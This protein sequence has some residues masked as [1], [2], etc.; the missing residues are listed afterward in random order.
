MPERTHGDCRR[1]RRAGVDGVSRVIGEWW[2]SD[3]DD[4]EH[5]CRRRECQECGARWTTTERMIGQIQM[6]LPMCDATVA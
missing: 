3:G 6:P 4:G 5:Y 1:C 2:S